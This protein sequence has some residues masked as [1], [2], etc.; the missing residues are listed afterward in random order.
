[1]RPAVIETPQPQIR[2]TKCKR[3]HGLHGRF[4]PYPDIYS[5]NDFIEAGSD[6]SCSTQKT[7][8]DSKRKKRVLKFTSSK[9]YDVHQMSDTTREMP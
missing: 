9:R 6:Q 4:A 8:N 2:P 3:R 1:M 7:V 5:E